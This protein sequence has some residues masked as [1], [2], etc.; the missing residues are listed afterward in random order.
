MDINELKEIALSSLSDD[1]YMNIVY[2]G[3]Q[4]NIYPIA[5]KPGIG[6]IRLFAWCSLHPQVLAESFLLS[7]IGSA[8][9]SK[10]SIYFTPDIYSVLAEEAFK[11]K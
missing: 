10:D 3:V 5:F 9:V 7:K 11:N 4:R 6:G 8:N 2:N 1:K